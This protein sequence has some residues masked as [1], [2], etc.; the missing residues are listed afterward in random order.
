MICARVPQFPIALLL[1]VSSAAAQSPVAAYKQGHS[2][3]GES[4]DTGP[5]QKPW[6]MEGIGEAHFPIT[7]NNPEV[8]RWFDQGNALLHSFW[9]YEAERA[10]RWCVKLEPGN[11]MPYWGLARSANGT[12]AED[13]IREAQ[14]RKEHASERERLYIDAVAA[15]L[16][17]D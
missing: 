6:P 2:F 4:F 7:T 16:L 1:L 15:Q 9:Y 11:P 10:F 5:R 13:F 12:R 14:K 17:P 3:H 8:Q